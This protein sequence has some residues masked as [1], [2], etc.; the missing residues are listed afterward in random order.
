[1]QPIIAKF[2]NSLGESDFTA[3]FA[4][5]FVVQDGGN[6]MLEYGDVNERLF[7]KAI[8]QIVGN[9]SNNRISKKEPIYHNINYLNLPSDKIRG[10]QLENSRFLK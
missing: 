1:M 3:G 8:S 9:N 10:L 7:S 5:D 6:G 4:P 2:L